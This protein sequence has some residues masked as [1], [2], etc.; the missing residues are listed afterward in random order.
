MTPNE[1]DKFYKKALKDGNVAGPP[2]ALMD[3]AGGEQPLEIS[4]G[5][6]ADP[7]SAWEVLITGKTLNPIHIVGSFRAPLVVPPVKLPRR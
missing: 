6:S 1:S 5:P 4:D 3:V 2:P 7:A